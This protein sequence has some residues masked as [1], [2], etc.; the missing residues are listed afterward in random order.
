M[1]SARFCFSFYHAPLGWRANFSAGCQVSNGVRIRGSFVRNLSCGPDTRPCY[2]TRAGD[3]TVRARFA[4]SEEFS[5]GAPTTIH[6][7]PC[8]RRTLCC[9]SAGI[10]VLFPSVHV[11]FSCRSES[12]SLLFATQSFWQPLYAHLRHSVRCLARSLSVGRK[13]STASD[14]PSRGRQLPTCSWL[15]L[16][17]VLAWWQMPF[18]SRCQSAQPR[19]GQ[20]SIGRNEHCQRRS[21]TVCLC[22]ST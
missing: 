11:A 22:G 10:I 17:S 21:F 5:F 4:C 14:E 6:T 8:S 13:R 7:K 1:Y 18:L 12:D 9:E 16:L 20:L 15:L 3:A 19:L 2:S